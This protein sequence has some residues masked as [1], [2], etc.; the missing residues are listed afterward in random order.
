MSKLGLTIG[1]SAASPALSSA[2]IDLEIRQALNAPTL[3]L[4]RFAELADEDFGS[5]A[6]GAEVAVTSDDTALFSG[7]ITGL[8]AKIDGSRGRTVSVKAYDKLHRLRK[9]QSRDMS[10]DMDLAALASALAGD[11][12]VSA[13]VG[14][15]GGGRRAALGA[16]DRSDFDLLASFAER[17]GRYLYLHDDTLKAMTLAGDSDEPIAVQVG[18]NLLAGTVEVS[19]EALRKSVSAKGWSLDGNE[20]RT[21]RVGTAS[22]DSREMRMDALAGFPD[23]G[24]RTI[25][26]RL[27]DSADE[28][29]M[30]AQNDMDRATA[31]GL[32]FEGMV[33]GDPAVRPG[34]ALALE[35]M[36]PS[37]DG[38]F[39]VTRSVHSFTPDAGYTTSFSTDPP[40]SRLPSTL[41]ATLGVVTATDDP[42]SRGR[43][44]VKYPAMSDT[45]GGW[46]PVLCAAAGPSKG[47]AALPEVDDQ[48]LVLFPD[49]DPARGI[50]L[51]GLFGSAELPRNAG[52]ASPRDMVLRSPG[53]ASIELDGDEK[54]IRL[55]ADEGDT[56]TLGGEQTKLHS[57]RDMV[58]EAPGKTL[59]IRAARV[60]FEQ[61]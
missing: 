57:A 56:L 27:F 51:G 3:A 33:D 47:I 29:K 50:V 31:R 49:G 59:K 40:S 45:D 2:L 23:L 4:L 13:D 35:G 37:F 48:V 28:A 43:A 19:A 44:K 58:I 32:S 54:I 24:E 18:A 30:A 22:Q 14:D 25:V 26:Q 7:E 20:P 15:S 39:V 55:D 1:G 34:R 53:G 61:A 12:G 42:N 41:V 21:E 46:L 38:P 9:R 17:H 60:E 10:V 16:S 5:I 6:I 52:G 36:G 8:A 11:I